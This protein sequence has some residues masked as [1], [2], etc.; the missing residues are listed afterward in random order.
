M[1]LFLAIYD[2]TVPSDDFFSWRTLQQVWAN[3]EPAIG[4]ALVA[5][6]ACA[7]LTPVAI[8]I[9]RRVGFLAYPRD[10]DIHSKPIPYGGGLAMFVAFTIA[11]LAFL[12][13]D[14]NVPGLLLLCGVTAALFVIDDQWGI[15]ALV[16]LGV[17]AAIAVAAVKLF[18]FEIHFLLVWL[19]TLVAFL[20]FLQIHNLG[21]LVLPITV[22]WILGMQNAANLLDGVDGLAAG[23]IG[24]TAVVL[25]V[26]SAGRQQDVVVLSAALVGVC[27]GF[28]LF[29]FHP[30]RIFMGD[31]GAYFLGLAV[32]LLSVAGV[33]KVAVAAAI[34][35][36]LLAM[37]LP[38]VDTGIA[39][40]RR[41]RNGKAAFDPDTEHIHHRLLGLGLTQR[42]TCLLFYCASGILGAIGLT[43]FGHRRILAVVIVLIIV[44]LSTAMGERLR[45]S[46]RRIPVPLGQAMR[47]L[48]VGRAAR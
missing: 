9:S 40:I 35:V 48:L 20:P 39:I 10:R 37:G 1:L 42:Q 43:V 41:R 47:E 3:L 21:L 4:P 22:L 11:C 36:P 6:G 2:P 13:H 30:A 14:P 12:R 7:L 5:L 17:Q 31:S 33:A 27:A 8:W 34:A 24:V 38:I 15:P 23:V 29:N 28:L 25:L 32:A 44:V 46:S 16:K 19:A 45:A 18:G 26:A